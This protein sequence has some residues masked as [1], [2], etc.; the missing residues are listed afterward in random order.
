MLSQSTWAVTG[1]LNWVPF[2]DLL[3]SSGGV[4][5]VERDRHP[6][7]GIDYPRMCRAAQIQATMAEEIPATA[8]VTG[9]GWNPL[10]CFVVQVLSTFLGKWGKSPGRFGARPYRSA[11]EC[12]KMA[13]FR[14]YR[15]D[16]ER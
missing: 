11:G 4:E 1:N 9:L 2:T 5:R 16:S 7:S 6:V 15:S 14:A 13:E 12:Q 3:G 8:A 10:K